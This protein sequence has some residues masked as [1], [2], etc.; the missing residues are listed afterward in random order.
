MPKSTAGQPG[1]TRPAKGARKPPVERRP[2][3]AVVKEAAASKKASSKM[4]A[5]I[6]KQ[7]A[8]AEVEAPTP[9]AHPHA[10]GTPVPQ[11]PADRDAPQGSSSAL[12]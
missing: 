4:W 10:A 8:E 5:Q 7:G 9:T 2:E 3:A 1:P 6:V 12:S 11:T